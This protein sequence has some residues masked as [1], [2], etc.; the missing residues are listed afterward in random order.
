MNAQV[1]VCVSLGEPMRLMRTS[2]CGDLSVSTRASMPEPTLVELMQRNWHNQI[3][4][5]SPA[6]VGQI[7]R[8]HLE[9]FINVA[10]AADHLM[11]HPTLDPDATLVD[12]ADL[13]QALN[14]LREVLS[15]A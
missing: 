1:V 3:S 15:D 13:V 7:R 11:S 2:D 14:R 6:D 9:A 8:D 12:I 5:P 10:A 4:N